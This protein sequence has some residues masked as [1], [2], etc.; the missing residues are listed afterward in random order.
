MSHQGTR[1][2][3]S[4]PGLPEVINNSTEHSKRTKRYTDKGYE[5]ALAQGLKKRNKLKKVIERQIREIE[6]LLG[7]TIWL[8]LRT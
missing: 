3:H 2:D 7:Q 1:S 6:D 8:M 4:N 5:H